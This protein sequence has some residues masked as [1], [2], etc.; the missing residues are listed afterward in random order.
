MK[1]IVKYQTIA[2]DGSDTCATYTDI[3]GFPEITGPA[4][5][6]KYN[7]ALEIVEVVDI[8]NTIYRK[9]SGK[10]RGRPKKEQPAE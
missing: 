5:R 1:T 6:I 8:H 2:F 3:T 7:E 9:V 10:K 4:K